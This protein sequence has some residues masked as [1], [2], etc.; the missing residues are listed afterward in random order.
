[1]GAAHVSKKKAST[2]QNLR[3]SPRR[4]RPLRLR[5]PGDLTPGE[6]GTFDGYPVV[7]GCPA[8]RRQQER[9]RSNFKMKRQF[10]HAGM[11]NPMPRQNRA[12]L[13]KRR[14]SGSR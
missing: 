2:R 12:R 11:P 3:C 8:V 9:S 13:P 5:V 10:A 6:I 14:G 4:G 1:M 7:A